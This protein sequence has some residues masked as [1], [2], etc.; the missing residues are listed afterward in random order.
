MLRKESRRKVI[1]SAFVEGQWVSVLNGAV[2]VG[3][4]KKVASGQT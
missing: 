1:R 2:R 4:N 3:T